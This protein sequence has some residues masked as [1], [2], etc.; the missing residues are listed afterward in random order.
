MHRPT[1]APCPSVLPCCPRPQADLVLE[2]SWVDGS[3]TPRTS[4]RASLEARGLAGGVGAF[5][6]VTELLLQV[7]PT[8]SLVQCSSLACFPCPPLVCGH[9]CGASVC[10]DQG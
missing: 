2:V 6:V 1:E 3:G 7:G 10:F 8:T 9:Q 5:G 4:K